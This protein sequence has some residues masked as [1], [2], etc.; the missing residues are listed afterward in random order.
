VT[1]ALTAF[2]TG[3][4]AVSCAAVMDG[5]VASEL[6]KGVFAADETA[7]NGAVQLMRYTFVIASSMTRF[8]MVA[9]SAAILLWSVAMLHTRF[10]RALPWVGFA[11]AL[12]GFLGQFSG[13]LRMN[14]HDLMLMVLGQGVWTGWT[15]VVLIR[16]PPT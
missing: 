9:A 10:N 16:R 1:A 3:A 7:R 14:T 5:L 11:I 13:L 2:A 15:G 12:L 4:M 6:A 8:Y